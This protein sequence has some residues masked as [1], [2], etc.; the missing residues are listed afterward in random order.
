[1]SKIIDG[2]HVLT[3]DE[4][5]NK[6]EVADELLDVEECSTCDGD[7]VHECECGD[8]HDCMVCSGSGKAVDFRERY[9]A[10]LR[11]ELKKLLAW[12]N[13]EPIKPNNRVT[14]YVSH[15]KDPIV[16][17]KVNNGTS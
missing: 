13:G 14:E 6:P 10:I 7:G 11:D 5:K 16:V 4:W 1:M 8:T 3:Y 15:S 9:E 2:V 12:K 17:F